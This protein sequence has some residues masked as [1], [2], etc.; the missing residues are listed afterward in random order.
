MYRDET[1]IFTKS[2]T[3]IYS[4]SQN[5]RQQLLKKLLLLS[6]SIVSKENFTQGDTNSMLLNSV[7]Y[8]SNLYQ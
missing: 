2:I 1:Y 6:F 3:A 7:L 8:N 4:Q 5:K